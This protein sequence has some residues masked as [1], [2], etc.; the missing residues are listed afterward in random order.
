MNHKG[1]SKEVTPILLGDRD[2][3][4]AHKQFFRR[5]DVN[6]KP[7]ICSA[8][9]I[10]NGQNTIN[11]A[12]TIHTVRKSVPNTKTKAKPCHVLVWNMAMLFKWKHDLNKTDN[13]KYCL[14]QT[15]HRTLK[16]ARHKV[17]R[18]IRILTKVIHRGGRRV[19]SLLPQGCLGGV[20]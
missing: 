9:T 18:P 16:K 13:H 6:R 11:S 8:D 10:R 1:S 15:R 2:E 17:I 5:V 3:P 20:V 7:N 4:N 19:K 12:T 14:W